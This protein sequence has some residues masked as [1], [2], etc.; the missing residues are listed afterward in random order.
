M[1]PGRRRL[2]GSRDISFVCWGPAR[3]MTL[4]GVLLRDVLVVSW[5]GQ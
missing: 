3:K 1:D 5:F 4:V 2:A